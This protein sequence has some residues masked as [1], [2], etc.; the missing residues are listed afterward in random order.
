MSNHVN[1]V[2]EAFVETIKEIGNKRTISDG[3]STLAR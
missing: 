2:V 3:E 1:D